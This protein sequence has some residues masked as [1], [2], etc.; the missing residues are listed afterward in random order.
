[1]PDSQRS[2]ATQLLVTTPIRVLLNTAYR[3]IYPFLPAFSRGLGV[4][5]T[6]LTVLLSVRNG[7]GLSAPLLGRVADRFGRRTSMLLGLGVFILALGAAALWPSWW[8]FALAMLGVAVARLLHDPALLAHLG[9]QTP[10]AQRGR[11]MGISEFGWSGA[12]FIGIPLLGLLIG[13]AGWAAPFAPLAGLG[14]LAAFGIGWAI[15]SAPALTPN[16]SPIEKGNL[17]T[18]LRPHLIAALSMGALAGLANE[19]LSVSYGHWMEGSFGLR[20]VEL[21]ATAIVIGA[22]ELLGEGAVATLADRVGKRRMVLGATAL[23]AA[24]YLLLPVLG[25]SLPLALAGVFLVYLCF[26]TMIVSTIPMVSE[27]IPEARSTAISSAVTLQLIGRMGG[28]LLG[29]ALASVGFA[30]AMGVAAALTV[31]VLLMVWGLVRE[32]AHLPTNVQRSNG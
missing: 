32:H 30:W 11:V 29:G 5:E 3:M 16:P 1:M 14:V 18:L 12:T 2:L 15:P 13:S 19:I 7:L 24:A 23:N 21:G 4:D 20:V 8:T 25:A 10:Y 17:R 28:A 6:T 26:E 22:A 9:D 31:V 27:L